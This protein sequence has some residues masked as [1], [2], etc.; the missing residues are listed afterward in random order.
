M[1]RFGSN[2]DENFQSGM[3]LLALVDW[4]VLDHHQY[5]CWYIR[6]T[7]YL[8][9]TCMGEEWEVW[10]L[11]CEVMGELGVYTKRIEQQRPGFLSLMTSTGLICRI[12]KAFLNLQDCFLL[13]W[14][15]EAVW[16][17]FIGFMACAFAWL[18]MTL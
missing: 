6:I 18:D 13:P 4:S 12:W 11:H 2:W 15:T 8:T 3:D 14:L 9:I 7:R 5:L 10:N 16:L 1:I 17:G